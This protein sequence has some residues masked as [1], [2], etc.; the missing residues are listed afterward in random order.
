MTLL[1]L[2]FVFFAFSVGVATIALEE[3]NATEYARGYPPSYTLIEVTAE[4][5]PDKKGNRRYSSKAWGLVHETGVTFIRT[6]YSRKF[7]QQMMSSSSGMINGKKKLIIKGKGQWEKRTSK[8]DYF[9]SVDSSGDIIKDLEKGVPGKVGSGDHK[10]ECTLRLLRHAEADLAFNADG[11]ENGIRILKEENSDISSLN[12]HLK[13][14]VDRL[15]YMLDKS[16]AETTSSVP[17]NAVQLK[18]QIDALEDENAK[19]KA[20]LNVIVQAKAETQPPSIDSGKI[21]ALESQITSLEAKLAKANVDLKSARQP[22]SELLGMAAAISDLQGQLQESDT[23]LARVRQE[24]DQRLAALE[25]ELNASRSSLEALQG[26]IAQKDDDLKN[27]QVALQTMQ[28]LVAPDPEECE[29]ALQEPA[30]DDLNNPVIAYLEAKT[31]ELEKKLEACATPAATKSHT[32]TTTKK[33]SDAPQPAASALT[34]VIFDKQ[35]DMKGVACSQGYNTFHRVFGSVFYLAGDPQFTDAPIATEVKQ[36]AENKIQIKS[37]FGARDAMLEMNNGNQFT[38]AE[39]VRTITV[40]NENEIEYSNTLKNLNTMEF[41]SN[42]ANKSYTSTEESGRKK[43]CGV[44]TSSQK[45]NE[46]ERAASV[47]MDV[48]NAENSSSS[49]A[50]K[51][52]SVSLPSGTYEAAT[53]CRGVLIGF[54]SRD[55]LVGTKLQEA[56]SNHLVR[57]M[58]STGELIGKGITG[59]DESDAGF[60]AIDGLTG[61]KI[62]DS[63]LQDNSPVMQLVHQCAKF[64]PSMSTGN[65]ASASSNQTNEKFKAVLSCEFNGRHTNIAACFLSPG[66]TAGYIELDNFGKKQVIQAWEVPNMGRQTSNG[67]E[68]ELSSSFNFKAQNLSDTLALKLRVTD[69]SGNQL[70]EDAKGRNGVIFV[71][72]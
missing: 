27:L 31:R 29:P 26:T 40:L 39:Q 10:R 63:E 53:F 37:T 45:K 44:K 4:C 52:T 72:N 69:A 25:E 28:S 1:R 60:K 23:Q 19:L 8:V 9:F 47:K 43:A 16:D 55:E 38:V 49:Q 70:F 56:L 51:P 36:L 41:M 2:F 66:G 24:G 7:N 20:E 46:D 59:K 18:T 65:N 33:Q 15:K 22:S 12:A 42:P 5:E 13:N 54:T 30:A 21:V 35:W 17:D 57:L 61:K 68:F 67:L 62:E 32:E 50:T 64:D 6:Q 71:G 34:E 11:L 3:A 48:A 14:E 58:V